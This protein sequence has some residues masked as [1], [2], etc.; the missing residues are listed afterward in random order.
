MPSKDISIIA[1]GSLNTDITALGVKEIIKAGEHTYGE[2]LRLGP[3]GKS[4][5]IAQM[6]SVLSGPNK[7]AMIGRTC[8]DPFNF[9]R[10]PIDALKE[11]GVNTEFVKV[12]DFEKKK[13]FPGIALIAVDKKGRNQIY[14]LPGISDEFSPEDINDAE[15]LFQIAQKNNGILVLTLELPIQTAIHAMKKANEYGLMVMLDPGGITKDQN[16]ESLLDEGIFLIKPNE[17]EA[18]I[19]TKINVTNFTSAKKA[20]SILLRKGIKNVLI[21]TGRDGAYVFNKETSLHIPIPRIEDS[22]RKDETGSGDQTMATICYGISEGKNILES[23]KIAI[24]SG[25]LQYH[26]TGIIPVTKEELKKYHNL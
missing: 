7:V 17:H 20:A 6:I 23:S 5:N 19:L 15:K 11:N 10:P 1:I 26:K 12:F 22:G 9:W 24:T 8:R 13:K 21:T 16:L 4:R 25:T 14:V 2:E 3:G 18:K